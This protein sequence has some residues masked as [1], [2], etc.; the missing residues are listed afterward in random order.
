ME[1]NITTIFY[2]VN[3]LMLSDITQE[4]PGSLNT[5]F[6]GE[7]P[8]LTFVGNHIQGLQPALLPFPDPDNNK[9]GCK[10]QDKSPDDQRLPGTC[11]R[12]GQ[13]DDFMLDQVAGQYIQQA[14]REQ[15]KECPEKIGTGG[16]M[17]EGKAEI[18][19]IG[20]NNIDGSAE[21]HGPHPVLLDFFIDPPDQFLLSV[22]FFE[23]G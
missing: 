1:N 19:D 20:G 13:Q 7:L 10:Y 21:Y 16:E 2:N 12:G 3:D 4:L 8:L 18:D 6:W 17:A 15:T 9:D 5:Q 23:I 22:A 14:F 11:I